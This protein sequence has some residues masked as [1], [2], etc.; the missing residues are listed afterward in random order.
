MLKYA[1][2]RKLTLTLCRNL[3]VDKTLGI[4]LCDYKLYFKTLEINTVCY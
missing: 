2:Q 1:W 3:S 4:T